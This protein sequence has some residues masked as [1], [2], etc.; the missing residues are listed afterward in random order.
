MKQPPN[1]AA[2]GSGAIALLFQAAH[3]WRVVPEPHCAATN[4][5]TL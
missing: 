5:E 2:P 3:T 4:S 1:P